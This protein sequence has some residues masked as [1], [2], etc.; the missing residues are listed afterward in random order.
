M[1]FHRFYLNNDIFLERFGWI[2]TFDDGIRARVFD[3]RPTELD[4]LLEHADDE[5]AVEQVFA[6]LRVHQSQIVVVAIRALITALADV[7]RRA[8]GRNSRDR[9]V[10]VLRAVIAAVEDDASR[11]IS[12]ADAA[13]IFK[14]KSKQ[15]KNVFLYQGGGE[16][17]DR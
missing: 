1:P 17:C 16:R 10:A 14:E 13:K 9:I 12:S 7:Q 3:G 11:V 5:I 6:R 2:Q 15:M 8:A 4:R